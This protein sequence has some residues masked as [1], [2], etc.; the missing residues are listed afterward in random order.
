M[1]ANL[2]SNK[3][4]DNYKEQ[5]NFNF[6]TKAD[7]IKS[8]LE[9]S[10]E[11]LKDN[12]MI[13]LYGDWGSGKSSLMKHVEFEINKDIYYPIFF[14][15]WEHE[16]DDNLALSL[17]DAITN[18]IDKHNKVIKDFMKAAFATLKCFASGITVKVPGSLTGLGLDM[19]FSGEKY[20][21]AFDESLKDTEQISFYKTLTDFKDK[22]KKV[23]EHILKQKKATK[24]LIFI[25]DLDRCEP[26]NVLNLITAIKLFFTY[27]EHSVYFC[28]LDKTAVNMAVKTKYKD[29]VKAEEYLEKV[30]DISF[31]MPRTYEIKEILRPFF[32]N[33]IV[34]NHVGN[35]KSIDV[36]EAFFIDI[37]FINPRRLKKVLNKYEIIKSFKVSSSL[38]DEFQK[39]IPNIIIEQNPKGKTFETIFTL[40]IIILYEFS[41]N[42]FEEIEGYERKIKIYA[43][44]LLSTEKEK[45][46]NFKIESAIK[47][48]ESSYMIKNIKEVTTCDIVNR[49]SNDGKN[50]IGICNLIFFFSSNSPASME[51][52]ILDLELNKK[53]SL[54]S[55]N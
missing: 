16:K 8:F 9:F 27:G 21:K 51:D 36:I 38:K 52:S 29:I 10:L 34:V 23:E 33:L 2:S 40:F 6:I 46:T 28:G 26:E 25:D 37:K 43:D 30:F 20:I 5:D 3:E 11:S 7:A 22:F 31:N 13:V 55:V 41:F 24:L 18:S 48:M 17:C 44:I 45:G 14:Q 4:L 12:K 53:Y 1:K 19:E 47:I 54:G 39:L 32:D 35:L 42:E 15:A 49:L 50:F